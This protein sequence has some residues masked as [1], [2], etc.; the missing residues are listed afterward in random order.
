MWSARLTIVPLIELAIEATGQFGAA[1]NRP[2]PAQNIR[3]VQNGDIEED[4]SAERGARHDRPRL[5][6]KAEMS[7]D[8]HDDIPKPVVK[9]IP[10]IPGVVVTHF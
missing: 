8:C 7:Y 6:S 2:R 9:N 5:Q 10:D 4:E 1:D 3:F